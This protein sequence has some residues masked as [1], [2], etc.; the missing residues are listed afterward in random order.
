MSTWID[1]SS[2]A[3]LP[4]SVF[5]TVCSLSREV[6]C[7]SCADNQIYLNESFGFKKFLSLKPSGEGTHEFRGLA[8]S[9]DGLLI[10]VCST[11]DNSNNTGLI[12]QLSKKDS[13]WSFIAFQ[14]SP[15][16]DF[17]FLAMSEDGTYL[18]VTSS[19]KIWYSIN[20]GTS[21]NFSNYEVP[22]LSITALSCSIDGKYFIAASNNNIIYSKNYGQDWIILSAILANWNSFII[23]N[24]GFF[25]ASE[26]NSINNNLGQLWS[27]SVNDNT[28]TVLKG[29][30]IRKWSSI[31][32][33]RDMVNIVASTILDD[34]AGSAGIYVSNDSG[35][36]FDRQNNI[37]TN[38]TEWCSVISDVDDPNFVVVAPTILY[39]FNFMCFFK[40]TLIKILNTRHLYKDSIENYVS[41]VK[42]LTELELHC[43]KQI[44]IPLEDLK[45]GD[46][47]CSVSA[48]CNCKIWTETLNDSTGIIAFA[49]F[50]RKKKNPLSRKYFVNQVINIKCNTMK[51]NHYLMIKVLK[52]DNK[53][54]YL[55]FLNPF[56]FEEKN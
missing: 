54:L 15:S 1:H 3:N 32:S 6:I 30:S 9:G 14:K 27:G 26:N 24:S 33:T 36:N 42:K 56:L 16:D 20:S 40:G 55:L 2:N 52:N 8:I 44:E 21:W 25:Y 47:V 4:N 22:L 48:K 18:V 5:Q 37:G 53:K 38:N 41:D 51:S 11:N 17:R 34:E 39:T 45:I 13:I 10:V 50:L 49:N 46:L 28:L 7:V 19:T 35:N 12:Y 31:S 23:N 43:L 29:S